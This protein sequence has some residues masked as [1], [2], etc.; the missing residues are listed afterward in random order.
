[1][2]SHL[3]SH[4]VQRPYKCIFEG[5]DKRFKDKSALKK[6]EII[7]YPEKHFECSICKKKFSRLHRMVAHKKQHR[8]KKKCVFCDYC[9]K[10]FYNKNYIRKHITHKHLYTQHYICDLCDFRTYNKPSLVMHIKY[11]HVSEMDRKCK[12]CKKTYKKHIYL[13]LHY[14]NTHSIKYKLNRVKLRKPKKKKNN[15]I[16]DEDSEQG[17]KEIVLQHVIK[18]EQMSDTEEVRDEGAQYSRRVLSGDSNRAASDNVISPDTPFND[19]FIEHIIMPSP[20]NDEEPQQKETNIYIDEACQKEAERVRTEMLERWKP[21]VGLRPFIRVKRHYGGTVKNRSNP[22]KNEKIEIT[23]FSENESNVPIRE[24]VSQKIVNRRNTK[25]SRLINYCDKINEILEK[26]N[27]EI[28]CEDEKISNINHKISKIGE[29]IQNSLEKDSI[30]HKKQI[31]KKLNR[32]LAKYNNLVKK[33]SD[34]HKKEPKLS[35]E[36]VDVTSSD[37]IH[38]TGFGLTSVGDEHRQNYEYNDEVTSSNIDVIERNDEQASIGDEDRQN[39]EHNCEETTLENEINK[40]GDMTRGGDQTGVIKNDDCKKLSAEVTSS[41]NY[42]NRTDDVIENGD[43]YLASIGGENRQNNSYN[44]NIAVLENSENRSSDMLQK[45]DDDYTSISHENRKNGEYKEKTDGAIIDKSD[46]D[47]TS[48]SD[49]HNIECAITGCDENKNCDMIEAGVDLTSNGDENIRNEYN[50][51]IPPSVNDE[52]ISGDMTQTG[53]GH[54]TGGDYFKELT[55]EMELEN[56]E[57][58]VCVKMEKCNE[59][60]SIDDENRLNNDDCT[61]RSKK[62]NLYKQAL[63]CHENMKCSHGYNKLNDKA[64]S[65]ENDTIFNYVIEKSEVASIGDEEI[66]SSENDESRSCYVMETGANQ[67]L[68]GDESI[69]NSDDCKKF[70]CEILEN[71]KSDELIKTDDSQASLGDENSQFDACTENDITNDSVDLEQVKIENNIIEE[72]NQLDSSENGIL[73]ENSLAELVKLRKRKCVKNVKSI[74]YIDGSDNEKFVYINNIKEIDSIIK[75]IDNMVALIDNPETLN[76]DQCNSSESHIEN[77]SEKLKLVKNIRKPRKKRRKRNIKKKVNTKSGINKTPKIKEKK[78][79]NNDEFGKSNDEISTEVEN[80]ATEDDE[81][82]K[83]NPSDLQEISIENHL[84]EGDTNKYWT[85]RSTRNRNKKIDTSFV[86]HDDFDS[87]DDRDRDFVPEG[88][89]DDD[90]E[91][92]DETKNKSDKFKLNTHQCYVCFKLYETKEKLIDHCKEHFDICNPKMLKKCPFC[93]YVTNLDLVKHVRLIHKVNLNYLYGTLKDRKNNNCNK[94]RFYFNVKNN[95]VDEIEVIPSIPNLNRQAYLKIDRKRREKN[96]KEV[97]KAKLVKKDGGWIVEKVLI[98]TKKEN[99]VLPDKVEELLKNKEKESKNG[100][101]DKSEDNDSEKE[102]GSDDDAGNNHEKDPENDKSV[103]N[104]GGKQPGKDKIDGKN[105]GKESKNEDYC[106]KLQRLY[107]IA[108]KNGQKMLFPCNQCEKICQ[109]LSALKLHSRRHDPNA[110][111]FK[112]KVWKYKL[113]EEELKKLKEDKEKSKKITKNTKNRYEKPKPIVN[114][115]KCD[116]KLKDFYEK[117]IK[118]GDIEF[119]QFLKIFNKMSRENVNDFS[120]LENRTEFGMHFIDPKLN[121]PNEEIS[122]TSKDLN[123][124]NSGSS[125]TKTKKSKSKALVDKMGVV[126]KIRKENKFKRTTFISRKEFLR[127]KAMKDS[128]RKKNVGKCNTNI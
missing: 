22:V 24:E 125:N 36:N 106:A 96:D 123:S 117:N 101:N 41:G 60:V 98:N 79:K 114:K 52:S 68:I 64:R 70:E 14:W 57:I 53:N 3:S 26:F 32:A 105:D 89:G 18:V 118:G 126:S 1:M 20:P 122:S 103:E 27:N 82:L 92:G 11:G 2:R 50:N 56:D 124:K 34:I 44:C 71:M 77:N 13:K 9:G 97:K 107:R 4:I 8:A 73:Y 81:T 59:L 28:V 69:L 38:E 29:Q 42:K 66:P 85:R 94:S 61:K 45:G 58:V 100:E 31:I 110:K 75:E 95:L 76:D 102:P 111:P 84:E 55:A 67:V 23:V 83:N 39:S 10:G 15:I 116:P 127:R 88:D 40:N 35:P 120:D 21:S 62:E 33:V 128:L 65:P 86:S 51:E 99:Y 93:E 19:L 54:T 46:I 37:V 25:K 48:I 121:P 90:D 30:H 112:K 80:I 5:C 78:I 47:P 7:H 104:N 49:E 17:M 108:K 113:S 91:S 74:R 6:H 16:I 72:V 87:D 63:I 43:D 119:W 115:H 12:I 109:T